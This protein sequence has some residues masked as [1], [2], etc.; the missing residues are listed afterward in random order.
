MDFVVPGNQHGGGFGEGE[1]ETRG[2]I[3]LVC[4]E[5]NLEG[6][7]AVFARGHGDTKADQYQHD[8]PKHQTTDVAQ[9]LAAMVR[10]SPATQGTKLVFGGGGDARVVDCWWEWIMLDL[11]F[12]VEVVGGDGGD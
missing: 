2:R 11:L 1:G 9:A 12:G 10:Q 4:A 7:A 6:L 3:G 5:G 8:W